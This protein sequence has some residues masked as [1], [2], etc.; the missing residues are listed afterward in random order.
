MALGERSR[1]VLCPSA[2][3]TDESVLSAKMRGRARIVRV[4]ANVQNEQE[5]EQER[6]RRQAMEAD[7]CRPP[8][9][10]RTARQLYA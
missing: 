5:H 4:R 10:R 7:A 9:E 6:D 8:E 1:S 3:D 2:I